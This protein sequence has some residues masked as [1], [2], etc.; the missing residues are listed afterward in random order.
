MGKFIDLTGRRFGRL[1]VIER[2]GVGNDGCVTWLCRCDCGNMVVVR[3]RDLKSG[4]TKSCG[5]Y[6]KEHAS[7]PPRMSGEENPSYKHGQTG[8]KLYWIWSG[9]LQ[10]C[11]NK[12]NKGFHLYGG[13]GI[14]VCEEWSNGFEAFYKWAMANGYSEGRSIDRIDGRGDYCPEN[15]RWVDATT[16]SNNRRC[17][18]VITRNG[19]THTLGEWARIKKLPYK[20]LLARY[21]RQGDTEKLFMELKK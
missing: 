16:Q 6:H 3:S 14:K 11:T 15:C 18:I 13:R 7:T 19:E 10:R 21:Y 17:N 4:A 5:C 1:T 20:T 2:K 9:M 12:N 8:S